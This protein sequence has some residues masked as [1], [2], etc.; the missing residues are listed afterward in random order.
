ML[1][2]PIKRHLE[3]P[4]TIEEVCFV[5]AVV[6]MVKK[7]KTLKIALDT[8]KLNESCVKKKTTFAK[9]G[10][11][12]NQNIC[13]TVKKQHQSSLNI[14]DR[15]RLRL[16]TGEISTGNKQALQFCGNRREKER[17]LPICEKI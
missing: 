13:R 3:T 2:R 16:W 12:N 9:Y 11:A 17:V 1:L 10:R 5:S 6:I 15:P 14:R 4:E 7:D 8:W